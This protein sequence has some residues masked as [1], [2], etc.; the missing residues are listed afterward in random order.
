MP[1]KLSDE[2]ASHLHRVDRDLGAVVP[3]QD[4]DLEEVAGAIRPQVEHLPGRAFIIGD[5]RLVEGMPHSV[6]KVDVADTVLARCVMDLHMGDIIV[7]RNDP[8]VCGGPAVDTYAS[9]T[10]PDRAR[11]R[12]RLAGFSVLSPA[13]QEAPWPRTRAASRRQSSS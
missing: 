11:F 7:L 12:T 2:T 4:G 8:A 6:P 10:C 1:W 5:V 3:F 9:S 13:A